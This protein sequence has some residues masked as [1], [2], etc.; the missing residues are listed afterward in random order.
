MLADLDCSPVVPVVDAPHE[1]LVLESRSSG[2]YKGWMRHSSGG[3]S[4]RTVPLS[5]RPVIACSRIPLVAKG[6]TGAL[7]LLIEIFG[8][9]LEKGLGDM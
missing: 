4:S 6:H 9:T 7:F 5:M 3:E 2:L 1:T 8:A